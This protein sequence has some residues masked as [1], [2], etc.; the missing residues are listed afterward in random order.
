SEHPMPVLVYLH[1][2]GW[3]L[4]DPDEIDVPVRSLANRSCCAIVSVQYRLAPEHN[5]PSGLQAVYMAVK[6]A[7][8]SGSQFGWNGQKLAVGGDS[9]GGNLEAAVSM[10]SRDENGPNICFQ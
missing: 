8:T 5:Y 6:W 1:G 7:S 4:G 2:G 10:L 3:V 9:A